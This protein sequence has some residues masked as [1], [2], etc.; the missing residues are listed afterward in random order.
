MTTAEIKAPVNITFDGGEKI[1]R[2]LSILIQK[3]LDESGKKKPGETDT[4]AA[5]RELIEKMQLAQWAV[6]IDPLAEKCKEDLILNAKVLNPELTIP[7][8]FEYLSSKAKAFAICGIA[9]VMDETVINW[10]RDFYVEEGV[11]LLEEKRKK[12]EE[13]ARKKAEMEAKKK[14]KKKKATKARTTKKAEPKVVSTAVETESVSVKETEPKSALTAESVSVKEINPKAVSTAVETAPITAKENSVI[15]QTPEIRV[16]KPEIKE[17]VTEDDDEG[18]PFPDAGEESSAKSEDETSEFTD[19]PD[20]ECPFKENTIHPAFRK[21]SLEREVS[22][23]GDGQQM[24][25][26][27]LK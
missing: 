9:G 8:L 11:K 7:L 14:E 24:S 4:Q 27:D 12:A 21:S 25:L 1:R 17:V 15:E 18:I 10:A 23:I 19:C 16:K 6:V 3:T 13:Q 5:D 22:D 2:E 26:F 20:D